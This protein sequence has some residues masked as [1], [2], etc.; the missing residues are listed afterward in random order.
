MKVKVE[1]LGLH[2]RLCFIIQQCGGLD[3]NL[4]KEFLIKDFNLTEEIADFV[5]G[6]QYEVMI[7]TMTHE[8]IIEY[9]TRQENKKM[10]KK[11]EAVNGFYN[12]DK[13]LQKVTMNNP[14]RNMF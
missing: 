1:Q 6:Y 10:K 2:T 4:R 3:W 5:K 14:Y 9:I 8:E 11:E 12:L 7:D 13:A